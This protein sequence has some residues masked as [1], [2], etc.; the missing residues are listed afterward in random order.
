MHQ[1]TGFILFI[2]LFFLFAVGQAKTSDLVF[3]L[4]QPLLSWDS[5]LLCARKG[6][7]NAKSLTVLSF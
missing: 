7:G 2:Y 5:C 4:Q 3:E 6:S 1:D